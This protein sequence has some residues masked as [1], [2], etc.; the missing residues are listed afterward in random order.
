MKKFIACIILA[1]S[2]T[3]CTSR[4]ERALGGGLIGA[5]A[6]AA[7]G[8]LA[9]RSAGGAVAG[10]VIGGA[11]GAILGAATTPRY[12]SRGQWCRGYD[13]YGNRASYRC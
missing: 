8:G 11:G 5:G 9:T 7:I 3:A 6:G 2:I 1:G 13:E 12:A 10:A 4:E